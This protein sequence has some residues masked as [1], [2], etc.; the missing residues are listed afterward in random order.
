MF[1]KGTEYLIKIIGDDEPLATG[2]FDSVDSLMG[3][4]QSGWKQGTT[5]DVWAPSPSA[6]TP[7]TIPVV[8]NPDYVLTVAD[9]RG[10]MGA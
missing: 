1:A 8:I 9:V 3:M 2:G 6:G 5:I 4:I 7:H 10:M